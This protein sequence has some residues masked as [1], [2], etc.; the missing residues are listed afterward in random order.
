MAAMAMIIAKAELKL[1]RTAL[2]DSKL[3]KESGLRLIRSV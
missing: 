2:S 1:Y 3:T